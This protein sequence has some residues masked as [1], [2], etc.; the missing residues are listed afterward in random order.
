MLVTTPLLAQE[1]PYGRLYR[2]PST[3]P[4]DLPAVDRALAEGVLMPSVTN[5][6]GSLDKPFLTTWYGKQAAQ[7]AVEVS[8]SH[9]GLIT[10]RPYEAVDWLKDA[11]KRTTE[12]AAALGDAVHNAVETL[13]LGGQPEYPA[14]AAAH[15]ASWRRFVDD[16]QPEFLHVE[17]TCF[18]VVDDP[19]AGPLRYAGTADF[20]ARINGLLVVGDYKSGRSIHT[21]A[22]LQISALA[23]ATELAL[24]DGTLLPMPSVDAGAVVHLTPRGYTVRRTD[25]EGHA[26]EVFCSLRR[27]WDFHVANLASREPLLMTGPVRSLDDFTLDRT[28]TAAPLRSGRLSRGA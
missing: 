26:W 16:F 6:I 25:V 17:A 27:L 10:S 21:E 4:E 15:V 28:V 12:K 5:V 2:H 20:I 9:P 8:R 24:E 14:A 11:A 1:S 7:A 13:A 19:V 18:G 3:S 23:H 22:G